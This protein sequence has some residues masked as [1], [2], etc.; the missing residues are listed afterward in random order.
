MKII[1]EKSD[2]KKTFLAIFTMLLGVVCVDLYLVVIRFIG[3]DY[4]IFKLAVFRNAFAI[5]PLLILLLFTQEY[6]KLFHNISKKF[7]VLSCLRGLSFLAMNLFIFVS[8]INVEFA[9][10]M[11]LTFSSP[12]FIVIF[13][14]FFLNDKVGIYRWS[15]IIIGFIGVILILRPT[16]DIFNFYSIFSILTAIAWAFT[17]MILKFIPS[18]YSTSKIQFYTLMFN[19]IGALFLFMILINDFSV[20]NLNDLLLMI[21]TGILGGSAAILFVFAYRLISV[22]KLASFEYFGIPSSFLLGWIFF[23]EAPWSQLFPGVL[24]IVAAGF[25]IIWRDSQKSKTV[26]GNKKFY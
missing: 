3:N 15:A 5:I 21:L 16:S 12:F 17:V 25:I 23:K 20:N 10:A 8:V 11:T 24:L 1:K 7:L 19:V 26:K 14:I 6:N 2:L 22:S 4:S 9:T 13:S 18:G